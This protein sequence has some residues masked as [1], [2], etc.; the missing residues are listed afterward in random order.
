MNN[1]LSIF[2][3]STRYISTVT[4]GSIQN[5]IPP[6]TCTIPM[7]ADLRNN[8]RDIISN[9]LQDSLNI[10]PHNRQILYYC[11]ELLGKGLGPEVG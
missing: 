9:H 3:H 6:H 1:M 11:A 8:L 10:I 7:S 5:I 4:V 2:I